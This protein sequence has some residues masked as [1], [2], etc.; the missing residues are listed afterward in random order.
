MRPLHV[1]TLVALIA[2][3]ITAAALFGLGGFL[4]VAGKLPWLFALT[5]F[6]LGLVS[7]ALVIGAF[8]RHRKSW[9]FLIA[10]WVVVGFCAFFAPPKVLDL[11][12]VLPTKMSSQAA[13]IEKRNAQIKRD[14]MLV[15][16]GFALPFGLMCTGLAIGRRDYERTA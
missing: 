2:S 6:A 1:A 8:R 9:A 16:L 12:R 5:L 15:C 11:P 7:I 4:M 10:M 3:A 14:V 13:M